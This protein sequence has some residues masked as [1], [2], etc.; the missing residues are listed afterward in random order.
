MY[1]GVPR[2]A[3][4]R[5]SPVVSA[6]SGLAGGALSSASVTARAMPQSST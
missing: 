4:A 3:P 5:V 2:I 1:A 6:R